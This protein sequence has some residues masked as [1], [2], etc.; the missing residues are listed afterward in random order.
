MLGGWKLAHRHA[1]LR[2]QVAGRQPVY[3]RHGLPE[4][5]AGLKR[6]DL[7]VDLNLHALYPLFQRRPFV[8]ELAEQ[9]AM[10][11]AN[12]SFE[13]PFKLRDLLAQSASGQA[14]RLRDGKPVAKC[15]EP[16]AH[17]LEHERI[18]PYRQTHQLQNLHA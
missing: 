5:D 9:E 6:A 4:S 18:R 1:D 12:P 16:K 15:I 13:S 3:T 17:P 11:I 7:F 2:D 8:Q 10:M 14:L